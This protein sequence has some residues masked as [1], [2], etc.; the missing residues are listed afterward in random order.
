M[1]NVS[2]RFVILRSPQSFERARTVEF[3]SHVPGPPFFSFACSI[4]SFS[5]Q[6]LHESGKIFVEHARHVARI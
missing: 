1:H 3:S 2:F 4:L 6:T 5:R